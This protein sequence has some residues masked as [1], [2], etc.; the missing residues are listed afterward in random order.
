MA[1]LAP[2]AG[3]DGEARVLPEGRLP[4]PAGRVAAGAAERA[5]GEGGQPPLHPARRPAQREGHAAQGD[6]Q[7]GV[8]THT[9]TAHTG[10]LAFEELD[11]RPRLSISIIQLSAFVFSSYR[12]V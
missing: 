11:D 8:V 6:S 12:R 5:Q 3:G 2:P 1:S 10:K 9:H 7:G 4:Q